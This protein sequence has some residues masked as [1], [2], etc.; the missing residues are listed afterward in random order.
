VYKKTTLII[1]I[2]L[3]MSFEFAGCAT[4]PRT[5]RP[6][7]EH[8]Y[9]TLEDI[10]Y[11]SIDGSDLELDIAI[12][13]EREGPFPAIV[14]IFG[15]GW[16][17]GSRNQYH[18]HIRWAAERG[19]VGATVDYRLNRIR[20]GKPTNPFPA[21]VHDSKCAIQWLRSNADEYQIDVDRI[22]AV[23][24][25]AGGH[26]ALMLALTDASDGL[27]GS[28]GD[29]DYSSRVQAAVGLGAPADLTALHTTG[30][31]YVVQFL[32]G[33]PDEIPGDYAKASPISYVS[34]N[35]PPILSIVGGLD[36]DVP[37]VQGE[38]LDA[39]MMEEGLNHELIVLEGKDHAY[40]G[41]GRAEMFESVFE[42]LDLYLK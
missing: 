38:L 4:A 25:A 14:F 5:V 41:W 20:D 24:F 1:T 12:P 30:S 2:L 28:C 31:G 17:G 27:E 3:S 22:G 32:G 9:A 16:A 13:T 10:T 35:D 23:G 39:R 33:T 18:D 40:L 26:L 34:E 15:R 36:V 7:E 42:F 21:Q 6:T 11:S 37:P 19:Y 29:L 8:S